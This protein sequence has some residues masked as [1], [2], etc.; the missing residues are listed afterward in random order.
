MPLRESFFALGLPFAGAEDRDD[1]QALLG[2]AVFS[3]AL[4]LRHAG[5]LCGA[6]AS[7]EVEAEPSESAREHPHVAIG[8]RCE[9][10][11]VLGLRRA[12]LSHP[13]AMKTHGL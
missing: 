13:K 10:G 12:M 4:R 2:A 3:E 8:E 7:W 5:G 9:P 6:C 1:L 11:E